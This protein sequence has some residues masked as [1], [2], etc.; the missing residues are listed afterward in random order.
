MN[1]NITRSLFN[2][3]RFH[4]LLGDQ[5]V[6]DAALQDYEHPPANAPPPPPAPE[7]V[8]GQRPNIDEMI[9]RLAQEQDQRIAHNRRPSDP[10]LDQPGPSNVRERRESSSTRGERRASSGGPPT[11]HS[12]AVAALH[13]PLSPRASELVTDLRVFIRV[14]NPPTCMNSHLPYSQISQSY[15]KCYTKLQS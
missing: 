7:A 9:E 13:D 1:Y 6:L 11:D 8:G 15:I 12:Y 14:T 5:E 10:G 4:S 2:T 3:K